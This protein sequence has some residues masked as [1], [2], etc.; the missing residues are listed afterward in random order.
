M[1]VINLIPALA[2]LLTLSS[3]TALPQSHSGLYVRTPDFSADGT[4]GFANVL[5]RR[6]HDDFSERDDIAQELG[7]AGEMS[8]G[9]ASEDWAQGMKGNL[10][11]EMGLKMYG[12]A[13]MPQA[14]GT[15][16]ASE[17]ASYVYRDQSWR[18]RSL[19]IM[20]NRATANSLIDAQPSSTQPWKA[21]ATTNFSISN[22]QGISEG[23]VG[24]P[25]EQNLSAGAMPSSDGMGDS[26]S[27]S[28][29]GSGGSGNSGPSMDGSPASSGGAG[30]GVGIS[31]ALAVAGVVG[32]AVLGML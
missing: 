31:G 2:V 17:N 24:N 14:G 8:L 27:S 11:R 21:A 18:F 16:T 4:A 3:S 5:Q 28:S 15:S 7:D 9:D 29:S 23:T 10:R 12:R 30:R 19:T 20:G 22:D 25:V 26:G 6:Q 1:L 32:G 13:P